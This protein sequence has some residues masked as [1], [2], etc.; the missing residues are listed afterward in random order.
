M[1]SLFV[2]IF[3]LFWMAMALIVVASIATTFVIAAREY[4][5]SDM[6]RRPSVGIQASE[7]M[8]RGDVPALKS[9]LAANKGGFGDRDVYI[10]GPDGMDILGRHLPEPAAR[11]LEYFN[12]DA[13]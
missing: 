1:P 6:M 5:T 11:R 8:A 4:E 2:R 12:R 13:E 9:W 10:V 3:L 7:V